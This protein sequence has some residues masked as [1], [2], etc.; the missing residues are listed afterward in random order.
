MLSN[1]DWPYP[2]C[3]CHSWEMWKM[4]DLG[5]MGD[6]ICISLSYTYKCK[7]MYTH[8]HSLLLLSWRCLP[9]QVWTL[10]RMSDYSKTLK[11]HLN[12][13]ACFTLKEGRERSL[14]VLCWQILWPGA[15]LGQ[16]NSYPIRAEYRNGNRCPEHFPGCASMFCRGIR[17]ENS[18]AFFW[19][20]CAC[21]EKRL[22]P[23]KERSR[24]K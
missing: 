23:G 8:T 24:G 7:D 13:W 14:Q 16:I 5:R 20:C 15:Q 17:L 2:Y 6:R 11:N 19:R 22:L 1:G 12:W 9:H 4:A 10:I 18:S 21:R 3:C